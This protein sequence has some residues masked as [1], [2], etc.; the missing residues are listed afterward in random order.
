MELSLTINSLISAIGCEK[1]CE[2][3]DFYQKIGSENELCI[4][5][6]WDTRENLKKHLS[7]KRFGVLRGAMS[8]LREP[9]EIIFHN[10]FQPFGAENA[11]I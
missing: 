11:G 5:E 6:Q 1:G 9:Y 10:D 2:R 7:S 8:L 3:C 4:L